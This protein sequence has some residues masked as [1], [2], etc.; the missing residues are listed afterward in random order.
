MI[1]ATTGDTGAKGDTGATGAKGDTGATGAKATGATGAKGDKGAQ[2]LQ[3]QPV[4]KVNTRRTLV[5]TGATG[6]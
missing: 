6:D 2:V 4:L 1:Q 5:T 3:A